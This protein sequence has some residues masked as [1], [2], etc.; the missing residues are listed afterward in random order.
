MRRS[1]RSHEPAVAGDVIGVVVSLEDV[2]D[3]HAE[4]ARELQI[5]V[6]GKSRVDHRG[7]T[8][9]LVADQVGGA[10]QIVVC[11]LAKDHPRVSLPHPR[12]AALG[13]GDADVTPSGATSFR[14]QLLTATTRK[15]RSERAPR[16]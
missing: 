10:T 1:G 6:D 9:V 5:P 8:R 11:D 4:V 16:G 7:D 14:L 15:W 13:N 2:L 3:P 12:T